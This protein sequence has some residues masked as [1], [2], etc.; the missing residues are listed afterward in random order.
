[1]R[2]IGITA[3]PVTSRGE[4]ASRGGRELSRRVVSSRTAGPRG[5]RAETWA[6]SSSD[7]GRRYVREGHVNVD[8]ERQRVR[9][10]AITRGFGYV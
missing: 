4:L 9:Q 6:A 3:T 8:I 2:S 7:G 1:M 5:A 10:L